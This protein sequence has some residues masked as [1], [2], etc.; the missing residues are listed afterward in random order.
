MFNITNRIELCGNINLIL[1][2]SELEHFETIIHLKHFEQ[3][4]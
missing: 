4:L 1:I 3:F 2:M